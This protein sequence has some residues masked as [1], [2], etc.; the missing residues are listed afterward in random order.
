MGAIPNALIPEMQDL[1]QTVCGHLER[2]YGAVSAFEHGPGGDQRRVGC[3]VD[4]AHLHI[5]PVDFDLS[6]AVAPHLP[7]DSCWSAATSIDCRE[8]VQSGEDYLYLEQPIGKA[9]IIRHRQLGSQV[10]R[11][12]VADYLGVPEEYNWRDNPQIEN[13]E[14]TIQAFKA[15]ALGASAGLNLSECA[16]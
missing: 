10:F 1:K 4:H 8:A 13:V 2:T 7:P 9:R 3:G 12:A 5:L 6:V 15:D 14:K 11:R 16:A